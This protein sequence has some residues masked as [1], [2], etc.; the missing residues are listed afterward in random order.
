MSRPGGSCHRP[1]LTA[2]RGK[3]GAT[4]PLSPECER[5]RVGGGRTCSGR[6]ASVSRRRRLAPAWVAKRQPPRRCHSALLPRVLARA[7]VRAA[8]N[9]GPGIRVRRPSQ[10]G[11]RIR[12]GVAPGAV[13]LESSRYGP[14][15]DFACA[16]SD[17]DP[18]LSP[19][20]M[21]E[22]VVCEGSA[23]TRPGLIEAPRH[24]RRR[25]D[26]GTTSSMAVQR[27]APAGRGPLGLRLGLCAPRRRVDAH[28]WLL[29]R[30]G[31]AAR[32][33]AR[34]QPVTPMRLDAAS[35]PCRQHPRR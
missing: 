23:I 35:G 21:S 2:L 10:G 11:M 30:S 25:S 13:W 34:R 29:S 22:V 28:T 12:A 7:S 6:A 32:L 15:C 17:P 31:E 5:P 18:H 33:H 16:I 8:A 14:D 3:Q 4:R 19:I 27:G 20:V 1:R 24:L 26:R 9:G